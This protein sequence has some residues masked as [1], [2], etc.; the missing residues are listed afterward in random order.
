MQA[1][2]PARIIMVLAG[3][4]WIEGMLRIMGI[5]V[6]GTTFVDVKGYPFEK[7]IP[8]GRNAGRVVEVQGGVARNIAEDIANVGLTPTF[9]SMVDESGLSDDL[10]DRLAQR[11][12]NTGY[13]G[14]AEGGLGMWLAIF[15]ET[16]DV[17]GSISRRPDTSGIE[18]ILI[19]RGDE[20][21]SQADSVCIEFDIDA[22][23]LE[24]TLDLAQR[25]GKKVYSPV[26][27]MA[28]ACERRD[29]L[30]KVSCLV[31]NQQ[32][33]G[34]LFSSRFD[35]ASP[36]EMQAA[37]PQKLAQIGLHSMV[38]T[39]GAQGSVFAQ[40]DGQSGCHSAHMVEV[41]DTTGA[42]DA[43]FSGIAIGLTYGKSLEE[44]C[45]IGAKLA[46]SAIASEENVCGRFS[47]E[48]FGL[49]GLLP[50]G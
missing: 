20:I 46:A 2:A 16:G 10:V 17:A 49:S 3:A 41:A 1:C 37:L 28:I 6:I 19:E 32:E 33:A 42:G 39:M 9:V 29:L 34:V 14:R 35:G 24:R 11:G 30:G 22:P 47:P 23:I 38:V 44:S 50:M 8:A 26:T 40:I 12:C 15:D 5:V 27:N 18:R 7:Y 45:S 31:C 13:I 43:F 25:H 48:E 4:N 36:E 21:I